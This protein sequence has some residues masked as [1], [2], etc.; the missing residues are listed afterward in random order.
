MKMPTTFASSIVSLPSLGGSVRVRVAGPEQANNAVTFLALPGM[1]RTDNKDWERVITAGDLTTKANLRA[2]LPDPLSNFNTAPSFFEFAVVRTCTTL[3]GNVR[4]PCR[5]DWLLDV[6]ASQRSSTLDD[7]TRSGDEGVVLAGH[8][9]GGGAAARFA[10]AHPEMVSRLVLVSPDV[11]HH[12]AKQLKVPT[13]LIWS[14]DDVINPFFWTRRFK[15]HP[16]LTLH[17]TDKG[18]HMIMESHADVIA[19]WLIQSQQPA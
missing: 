5:E 12:V 2:I 17:A 14:R 16:A 4:Y 8:S 3:F 6:L 11:E 19:N 9:W 15:G 10:V 1:G 7:E 18:G 13:L